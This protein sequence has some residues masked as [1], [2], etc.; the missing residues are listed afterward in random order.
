M[1]HSD[2]SNAG[3]AAL[4]YETAE[5]L[6]LSDEN[7]FRIR[8]YRKAARIIE[9]LGKNAAAMSREELLA[10][11]GI[12]KGIASHISAIKE[13]GVFP[14]LEELR[15]K[16]PPGLREMLKVEGIGA[17]RARLLYEKLGVDSLDKLKAAARS[18]E[19]EKIDGLGGKVQ[20]NILAGA[21]R[22]RGAPERMLYWPALL[23]AEELIKE[24]RLLSFERAAYAGSLR[25]GRETVGDIDLLAA[26]RP[27]G[28]ATG[29][30]AKL[31][32]VERVLALGPAK[33]S[34]R[35]KA[36]IQCDF[37]I[38]PGGV[39]GA[40]LNYFTGSKEHNI[41]LREL[42]RKKGLS[43][44][45]YGLCRLSDTEHK[46]P[47]AAGTEEEIYEALGLQFIPPELREGAGEVALA[48]RKLIPELVK[49]ADIKGDA[50]N[51]TDFSDGVNTMEEMVR[52]ASECG[53]EW[54]FAGDHS[55]PLGVVH[56]LDFKGY[57]STRDELS[58]L[59]AKFPALKLGRSIEMEILKDGSLG[60]TD[61]EAAGTELVIGAV[62]SSF[63]L[64]EA[65]MT[66]RMLKAIENPYM[67]AVA[68]PS[69]RLIGR[70]DPAGA[71]DYPRLFQAAAGTGA[72][73]EI[74]GQPDRQDL[75]DITARLAREAGVKILLS[76]DA[77]SAGQ[78]AYMRIAVTVARR[79][80]LTKGD[81]LNSLSYK[82]FCEWIKERRS[83]ALKGSR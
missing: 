61:K 68:H 26:G 58:A 8:A 1:P 38:V 41:V 6:E 23:L 40:A 82:D 13:S 5:L 76:T 2:I 54:Y 25:R 32:Q 31:P 12:G 71:L 42:A 56:G 65:A 30:F 21:E 24:L 70:R 50:H 60:F 34:I 67:D 20:E 75:T 63:K 11:N 74:N 52:A 47:L 35:L 36:G 66:A 15:K 69:G 27:D 39:Y 57:S 44:S 9:D 19:I 29:K 73:F 43:L 79:A 22:V 17:K 4:F 46:Y 53:F 48:S 55:I 51:H 80:G 3:V 81:V 16:F 62:H 83:R 37:R 78:L 7:Q 49:L 77:H 33:A 18:G 28:S 10:V 64:A 14:E 59:A 72:A 45:E